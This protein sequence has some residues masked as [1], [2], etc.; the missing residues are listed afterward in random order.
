MCNLYSY[1]KGQ[2]A[3]REL[4][5]A[6]RDETGNL[7]LLPAIFPDGLAPVV[8]TARDGVREITMMRWGFPPPPNLGNRP[9][10]NV[11]NAASP[12]WRGWLKAEF[13]CLVPFTSF[14]EYEDTVPK[15]TPTWF[16]LSEQRPAAFFAGIWRPWT[17]TRG[18][19]ATPVDGE[20]LLFSFL[21]TDANAEVGAIHPKAMPAI[22]TGTEEIEAWL[23]APP[24]EALR[25]QRPLPDGAL[26]VVARGETRDGTVDQV[27]LIPAGRKEVA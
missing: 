23:N 1:T 12:Y 2:A 25:L 10:T 19:K 22:L 16:A 4:A 3:I 5:K 24:E 18:T 13:R 8:R 26:H 27:G 6:M 20:H 11:R 7:P 9:V 17:G 21:T 15:K 14:C